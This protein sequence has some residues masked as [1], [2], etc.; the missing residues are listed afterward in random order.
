MLELGKFE[1][2]I[3]VIPNGLEKYMSFSMNKK[4][5]FIDSFWFVSSSLDILVKNLC[6]DD[7]KYLSP[8]FESNVLDLSK[9]KGFYPYEY[10]SDFK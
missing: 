10:M 5:S 8:E 1:M 4:L 9:Q 2:K 6:K 7:S 3:N